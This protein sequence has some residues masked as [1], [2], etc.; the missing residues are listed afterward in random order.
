M[1]TKSLPLIESI[2]S[3]CEESKC[4]WLE[5]G[6]CGLAGEVLRRMESANLPRQQ[7]ILKFNETK[8]PGAEW[9]AEN[10]GKFENFGTKCVV[11]DVNK[12]QLWE[13][14]LPSSV[15][16]NAADENQFENNSDFVRG[17]GH[18]SLNSTTVDTATKSIVVN[19]VSQYPGYRWF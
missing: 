3:T 1:K 7:E 18:N 9:L 11:S 2:S 10:H 14:K 8:A 12:A 19:R 5:N 16:L 15:I 17:L 4:P 6:F 13:G